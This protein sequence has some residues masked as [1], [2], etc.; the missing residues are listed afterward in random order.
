MCRLKNSA[1]ITYRHNNRIYDLEG[2]Y[3][4]V[5]RHRRR[6]NEDPIIGS[7]TVQ[8]LSGPTLRI[9]FVR[10]RHDSGQWIA[11]A[12]TDSKMSS[13]QVC[14]I[15]TRRWDIEVF[16]KMIKQHMSLYGMQPR[17]YTSIIGYISIVFMRYMMFSYYH[18]T[19]I[20]E[21][22]LPGMFRLCA[23][24]LQAATI[25]YCLMLVQ[26]ELIQSVCRNPMKPIIEYVDTLTGHLQNFNYMM[27]SNLLSTNT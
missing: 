10:D 5:C 9:V 13:Q 17:N 4:W 25:E 18:R 21:M 22:T 27:R 23:K 11:L 24:Q 7:I 3:Q 2:L 6:K 15:Y 8:M 1:K 16:F 14:R 20:D 26:C 12:S 19:Q